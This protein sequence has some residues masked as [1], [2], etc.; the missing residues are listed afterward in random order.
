MFEGCD[1]CGK[2]TQ[3]KLLVDSLKKDGVKA[4]LWRFPEGETV[5]GGLCRSYLEKKIE[6]E[7]HAVHLLFAANRWELVPRM[8]ELLF[9]GT[10]LIVD[11][12][13]FSGV[14]FSAAKKTMDLDW[15]IKPEVGLPRPDAVLYLDVSAEEAAKRGAFGEERYEKTDFQKTVAKNYQLLMDKSYWKKL[16]A[17]KSIDD[18]HVEIKDIVL[19]LISES[20]KQDLHQ[21]WTEQE[22]PPTKRPA[23]F[24][25][26]VLNAD[27]TAD[28]K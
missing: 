12:Y 24:G 10:T 17:S 21:L 2:T 18:L 1:R 19:D 23:N 9:N 5:V 26:P 22:L 25:D 16:D 8:K 13:A 11:R 4:E 27:K 6:L 14:A 20:E 7:D 28:E 3:C 15:C